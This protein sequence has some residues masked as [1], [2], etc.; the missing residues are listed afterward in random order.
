MAPLQDGE[1]IASILAQLLDD[2]GSERTTRFSLMN[3]ITATA[4]ETRDA[5][6]RWRL[7]ELG[8]GIGA[9][10]PPKQPT[11]LG[12]VHARVDERVVV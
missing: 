1:V 5:E 9:G 8:G 6:Q 3:A 12:R 4:R 10:L 11:D 2:H 7:E